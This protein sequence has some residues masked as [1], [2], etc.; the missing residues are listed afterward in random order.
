M[1]R[2]AAGF[3][4][5][6]KGRIPMEGG[7]KDIPQGL[8]PIHSIDFIGTT[9][10]VPLLQNGPKSSFSPAVKPDRICAGLCTG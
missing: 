5:F 1:R 9:E 7:P 10:V 3:K 2:K 6:G 8:K 4:G